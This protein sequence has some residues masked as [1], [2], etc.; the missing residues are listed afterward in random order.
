MY[1]GGR[2]SK[3]KSIICYL[4]ERCEERITPERSDEIMES[5]LKGDTQ[6]NQELING[7]MRLAISVATRY[8]GRADSE[9]LISAAALG[10]CQAVAWAPT[11]MRDKEIAPYIVTTVHRFV[12]ECC[13][14]T[15]SDVVDTPESTM[16]RA[17]FAPLIPAGLGL[18][19]V[20]LISDDPATVTPDMAVDQV[21]PV[22]NDPESKLV[23]DARIS[24][25]GLSSIEKKVL[26]HRL[27]GLTITEISN[28]TQLR[29]WHISEAIRTIKEKYMVKHGG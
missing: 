15:R 5:V 8:V 25:L 7:Y 18:G 23:L 22:W 27:D 28:I 26:E 20:E 3:G 14:A 10:L 6:Y 19:D 17:G 16:R 21:T 1:H 4:G 11:R 13:W 2:R 24:E 12:S 29:H 9:E